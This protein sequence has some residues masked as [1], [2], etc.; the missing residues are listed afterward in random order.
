MPPS[1]L[2]EFLNKRR[3]LPLFVTRGS[4]VAS[5]MANWMLSLQLLALLGVAN[6]IPILAT[7]LLQD[8]FRLPLDCGLILPDSEPLFGASKTFRGVVLSVLCTSGAAVLLH[9]DW[10]TGATIAAMS[11]LG[12]LFSSFIKR[13]VHLQ[14]H[15]QVFGLDQIP[16]ALLPL[17]VIKAQFN[18]TGLHITGLVLAFIVLEVVLSRILF[19]LKIRD[20]PY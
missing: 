13:R 6:G 8:R 16:E 14:P 15:A 7:K 1:N 17:L 11:M 10:S 4:E 2:Q 5:G 9:L 3:R 19:R 12:D 20:R 18:L